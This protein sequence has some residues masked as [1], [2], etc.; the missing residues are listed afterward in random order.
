MEKMV[1]FR[2]VVIHEYQAVE[3][4]VIKFIVKKGSKDFLTYTREILSYL[5]E[6]E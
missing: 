4:E 2:N 1:G 6:Q 3:L 5:K